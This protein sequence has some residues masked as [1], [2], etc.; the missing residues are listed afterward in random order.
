MKKYCLIIIIVGFLFAAAFVASAQLSQS[1]A[2]NKN[3]PIQIITLSDGTVIKGRIMN[4]EDNVFSVQT[5]HMGRLQISAEDIQKIENVQSPLPP[6]AVSPQ[7]NTNLSLP[8]L[9]PSLSSNQILELKDQLLSDPNTLADIQA[10]IN[11]PEIMNA[12]LNQDF[13][14]AVYTMD[15][16]TIQN[17][18]QTQQLLQNPKLQELMKKISGQMQMESDE[19]E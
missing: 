8:S 13:I 18:P 7:Q 16:E 1:S 4:M 17:N 15:P 9:S 12:L 11:D 2:T 3:N 6:K 10:L 19:E 14:Q 5:Q